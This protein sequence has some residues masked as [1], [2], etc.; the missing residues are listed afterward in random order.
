M[1][2]DIVIAAVSDKF[3]MEKLRTHPSLQLIPCEHVYSSIP[4]QNAEKS[5][6]FGVVIF[7]V[8]A[9]K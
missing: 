6:I 8:K 4:F 1:H 2:G 5:E 3:T 9:N 7:S